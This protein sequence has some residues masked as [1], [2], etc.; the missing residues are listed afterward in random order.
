M[1]FSVADPIQ[2]FKMNR[3]II[4]GYVS[5]SLKRITL[6]SVFQDLRAACI[7][8]NFATEDPRQLFRF[9]IVGYNGRKSTALCQSLLQ[10]GLSKGVSWES[11]QSQHFVF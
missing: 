2:D 9:T 6:P 10:Q 3:P 7:E 8:R 1:S 11:L 4:L 5:S